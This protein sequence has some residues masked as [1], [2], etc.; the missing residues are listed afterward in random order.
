MLTQFIQSPLEDE[1]NTYV[2][3][4]TKERFMVVAILATGMALNVL[5][6]AMACYLTE[7]PISW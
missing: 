2:S 7:I 6:I 1:H 3:Q 5:F 4:S